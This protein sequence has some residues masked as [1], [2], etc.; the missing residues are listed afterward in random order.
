MDHSIILE[1]IGAVGAAVAFYLLTANIQNQKKI[2]VLENELKNHNSDLAEI[3]A[4]VKALLGRFR[5]AV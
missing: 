4:D 3:K 2:A 5:G 1:G